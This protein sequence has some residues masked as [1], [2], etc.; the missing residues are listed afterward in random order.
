MSAAYWLGNRP[1]GRALPVAARDT[2]PARPYRLQ[3]LD[4]AAA[5]CSTT[6]VCGAGSGSSRHGGLHDPGPAA[7]STEA[8]SNMAWLGPRR[9]GPAPATDRI[10]AGPQPDM[11]SKDGHGMV[12]SAGAAA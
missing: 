11:L 8:G 10:R 3:A 9:G 1:P 12:Y 2:A 5:A 7:A 4:P 6:A